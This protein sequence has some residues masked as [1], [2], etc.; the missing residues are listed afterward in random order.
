MAH[1]DERFDSFKAIKLNLKD[2]FKVE[3]SR[4]QI[5]VDFY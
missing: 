2:I 5:L 4:M 1:F 3:G